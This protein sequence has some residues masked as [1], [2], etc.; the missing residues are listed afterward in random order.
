MMY[1]DVSGVPLF[2]CAQKK[3]NRRNSDGTTSNS[4]VGRI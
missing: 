2:H 1:L 3:G 4:R